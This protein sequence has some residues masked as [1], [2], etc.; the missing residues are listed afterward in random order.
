MN[1]PADEIDFHSNPFVTQLIRLQQDGKEAISGPA[2]WLEPPLLDIATDSDDSIEALLQGMCPSSGDSSSR[3]RWHWLIGSP[4]N[5]KSAKLG[6]IARRLL[7]SHYEIV[8]ED[9]VMIGECDAHWLPYLLEVRE[10]GQPYKFAYLVQDASVVRRPFGAVCKPEKD[11]AEVLKQATARGRSL[12]LC[13]NWGVLQRLFD[14]G[15]T[16]PRVKHEAWFRAVDGAVGKTSGELIVRAGGGT[17]G[18]KMVFEEMEVTYEFLD[19][20]SL[21][22]N[23]DVFDRLIKEATAVQRWTA[24]SGCPSMSMCPFK[25]NRD[26]LA[27]EGFRHNVLQILRRAEVLD[28]QII[29]FREAVALLSVLLAGCPDDQKGHTPCEWVHDQVKGNKLFNLLARRVAS[30]LFG[31]SRPQGLER[32]Q[33]R[34]L[35]MVLARQ[36]QIS[37][38]EAIHSLLD[39]AS[40]VRQAVSS[41]T[42]SGDLSTD[43][44]VDRLLGRDGIIPSLDPAIEPRHVVALDEF[45][46]ISADARCSDRSGKVFSRPGIRKIEKRCFRAWEEIFDAIEVAGNPVTGQDLYFWVRRWQTTCLAWIAAVTDGLTALQPELDNYLRI[47]RT[48]E[49]GFEK[50]KLTTIR[51]LENVLQKLLS[52]GN[53]SGT[54]EIHVDLSTSLRL[55]GRWAELA[56]RPHFEPKGARDSNALLVKMSG[57]HEFV[58]TADTFSWLSRLHELNL[59]EISFNPDVLESFRRTQ[60]QA[61]AASDYSVQNDDITI[62][63]VDEEGV[64]HRIERIRG[65]LLERELQ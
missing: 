15:Q 64:E 55:T 18:E 41:I 42:Q 8:S 19:T 17:S 34:S 10:K 25:A 38:L 50:L 32:T 20:C 31:A 35:G 62:V 49:D 6:S 28:G 24:C 27:S 33:G 63:I 23:S 51:W 1:L 13:T 14:T 57:S 22:V 53:L 26:D 44:G 7:E 3:G 61:A 47:L 65:F 46:A 56:F 59:S 11:L 30:I 2:N 16:N 29:V 43:V 40:P 58:V 48:S 52:P 45:L 21:L 4:G 54:S 36:E 60:A 39:S 12:L 5:G 37:A 9:G